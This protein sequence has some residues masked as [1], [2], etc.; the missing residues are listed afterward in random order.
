MISHYFVIHPMYN[1]T[2]FYSSMY[3]I[4]H[5]QD[6]RPV[7]SFHISTETQSH[8]VSCWQHI[9]VQ[10]VSH[11]RK[12]LQI[13]SHISNWYHTHISFIFFPHPVV[14]SPHSTQTR[15]SHPVWVSETGFTPFLLCALEKNGE[16]GHTGLYFT[17]IQRCLSLWDG[18][19]TFFCSALWRTRRM[20]RILPTGLYLTAPHM[21][22]SVL[23][24][25]HTFL[26]CALENM[27]NCYKC[28]FFP[29][30]SECQCENG[31]CF[32]VVFTPRHTSCV[33]P[34]FSHLLCIAVE[35]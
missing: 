13:Q 9:Y 3:T 20:W 25:F 17:A 7:S 34:T 8:P 28:R 27:E 14:T 6:L 10:I 16:Y 35:P 30:C 23:D 18:F 21:C 22:L 33:S 1:I 15:V 24:G 2:L 4:T 5:F 19:H 11:Q 26:L 31:L 12:A 32:G 29:F